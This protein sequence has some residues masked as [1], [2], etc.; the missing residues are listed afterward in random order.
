MF[1]FL[2]VIERNDKICFPK[3]WTSDWSVRSELSRN[4]TLSQINVRSM[5]GTWKSA[6]FSSFGLFSRY[7]SS[8][9]QQHPQDF[10][11]PFPHTIRI[12]HYWLLYR[13]QTFYLP[14]TNTLPMHFPPGI[15]SFALLLPI[16]CLHWMC[17]FAFN[18]KTYYTLRGILYLHVNKYYPTRAFISYNNNFLLFQV[19]GLLHFK[20]KM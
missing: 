4:L 17:L 10:I 6:S 12:H 19:S 15:H 13:Q 20:V 1:V 16:F 8:L 9:S 18:N 11:S 14:I 2:A 5:L 3:I 7:A